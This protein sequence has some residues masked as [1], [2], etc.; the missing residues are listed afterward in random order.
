MAIEH[1]IAR[2]SVAACYPEAHVLAPLD[3][4]D[5]ASCTPLY[6]SIPVVRIFRMQA[7]QAA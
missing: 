3:H 5:E 4:L 6:K 7:A 2:G 1:D